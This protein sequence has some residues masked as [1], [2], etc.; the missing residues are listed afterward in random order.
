[1]LL[2]GIGIFT[3]CEKFL[4][5][6]PNQK[7]AVPATA[8]DLRLILDTYSVMNNGLPITVETMADNFYVTNTDLNGIANQLMRNLYTWQRDETANSEWTNTYKSIYYT[9]VVLDELKKLGVPESGEGAAVKGSALCLQAFYYYLLAQVFAMPYEPGQDSPYGLAIRKDADFSTAIT[10]ATVHETYFTII[11]LLKEALPLL[12]IQ[13][14]LKT[15]PTKVMAY[16]ML[17][18]I[19]LL[20]KNYAQAQLYADSALQYNS[21]L[22]NFNSLNAN[23]NA[24]FARFNEEVIFHARSSTTPILGPAIAKIDSNLYGSYHNND[25]RKKIY[26]KLNTNGSVAFKGDY[27]GSGTSSGYVFWGLVTDELYLI[28]AEC[29]ARQG[30]Y[31]AAMETLNQLLVTR[32][33]TGSFVPLTATSAREALQLIFLERRKELLFRGT[34]WSDLRRFRDESEFSVQPVRVVNGDTIKLGQNSN[35]YA[36]PIPYTILNQSEMFQNPL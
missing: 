6:K 28:R 23:A 17:A 35:R 34:R 20:S 27:D 2:A 26:F 16:G 24:P 7:L 30:R 9:N 5:A 3:S 12:P 13:E 32:W 10:R 8:Q 11:R 1:M 36:L 14:T 15:R 22:I 25:L 29:L 18:K 4:D 19:Y 33:K 31:A 21:K